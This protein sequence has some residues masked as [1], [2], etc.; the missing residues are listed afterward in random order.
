M[1]TISAGSKSHLEGAITKVLPKISVRWDG[2]NWTNETSYLKSLNITKSLEDKNFGPVA[3]TFNV[4]VDNTAGRFS[5]PSQSTRTPKKWVR[6]YAEINGT[7]VLVLTG[8]I[9]TIE[10]RRDGTALL[11]GRD[12][13]AIAIDSPA[14]LKTYINQ[15]PEAIINDLWATATGFST[16]SASTGITMGF[17]KFAKATSVWDAI[18]SVCKKTAGRVNVLPDGTLKYESLIGK[19]YTPKATADW[20]CNTDDFDSI[21]EQLSTK[22]I[23]NAVI[24]SYKNKQVDECKAAYMLLSDPEGNSVQQDEDERLINWKIGEILAERHRAPA[25][26]IIYLKRGHISSITSVM[27]DTTETNITA[28]CSVTDATSGKVTLSSGFTEG[29]EIRFRYEVS[30]MK[31]AINYGYTPAEGWTF[32]G[33]VASPTLDYEFG[34]G[35]ATITLDDDPDPLLYPDADAVISISSISSGAT[36]TKLWIT[37]DVAVARVEKFK[38]FD[39]TSITVFGRQE[40]QLELEGVSIDDARRVAQRIVDRYKDPSSTT[41]LSIS[42]HPELDV[43]DVIEIVDNI[44][45]NINMDYE[46]ESVTISL[47]DEDAKCSVRLRQYN[48]VAWTYTDNGITVVAPWDVKKPLTTPVFTNVAVTQNSI[49]V[50]WE[51]QFAAINHMLVLKKGVSTLQTMYT[52]ANSYTFGNLDADTEYTIELTVIG[53]DGV[54][55]SN[56][57]SATTLAKS[58]IGDGVAPT[59]P[60]GLS[61]SSFYKNGKSY[62]KADWNDNSEEDLLGYELRW[63][64]DN[65]ATWYNA[66]FTSQSE[67]VIEVTGNGDTTYTVYAQVRARDNEKLQSGWSSSASITVQKDTSA[68][69]APGSISVVSGV[70]IIYVYWNRVSAIDLNYYQ[71][72]RCVQTSNG[73]SFSGYVTIATLKSTDYID[74]NLEYHIQNDPE[75]EEY[76]NQWRKY[77]YRVKAVDLSGNGSSYRESSSSYASQA[78]GADIAVNSVKA[79]HIEAAFK[80]MAGKSI[81]AGTDNDHYRMTNEGFFRKKFSEAM[82]ETMV[83]TCTVTGITSCDDCSKFYLQYQYSE[84]GGTTW[85]GSW[86]AP[87]FYFGIENGCFWSGFP[88][89]VYKANGDTQT[90]YMPLYGYNL[91]GVSLNNFRIKFKLYTESGSRYLWVSEFGCIINGERLTL[92]SKADFDTYKDASSS[93][94]LTLEWGGVGYIKADNSSLPWTYVMNAGLLLEEEDLDIDLAIPSILKTGT[95]FFDGTQESIVVAH[96]IPIDKSAYEILLFPEYYQYLDYGFD[97]ANKNYRMVMT[98]RKPEGTQKY[99]NL[100]FYAIELTSAGEV[101]HMDTEWLTSSLSTVFV[102]DGMKRVSFDVY[103]W[104]LF[105]FHQGSYYHE[106]ASAGDYGVK[107]KQSSGEIYVDWGEGSG[108]EYL[109]D[110]FGV[111]R[112]RNVVEKREVTE[113]V[114]KLSGN[115]RWLMI[116]TQPWG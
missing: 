12:V 76:P 68:P 86:L 38:K 30:E 18:S 42:V 115:I 44:H 46:I 43:M 97:Y 1:L 54:T 90:L 3:N 74:E 25:D 37:G 91:A 19:N 111:A 64:Y 80:I 78:T 5:W 79:N 41:D 108:E 71:L 100:D 33:E 21:T 113:T 26:G 85:N 98:A 35:T 6:L 70:G 56:S 20:T 114:K 32:E 8:V 72:E 60:T 51:R 93:N 94:V 112:L 87:S 57:T 88:T 59:T 11:K 45:T 13:S 47:S 29:D 73:G 55:Y 92:G 106:Y 48:S 107:I 66:G 116:Q 102:G 83:L 50:S 23:I 27:N 17:M 103:H 22:D 95:V 105:N 62:V 53:K 10:Q 101:Q 109:C 63:N 2:V 16:S 89:Y 24:V 58:I 4:I 31:L 36:L 34:T 110:V 61:L 81:Q 104:G 7:D 28:Y 69:S 77:K 39:N 84:D 82:I 99:F 65:G 49:T 75:D 96:G 40:L 14:P 15:S 67:L 52:A 9:D